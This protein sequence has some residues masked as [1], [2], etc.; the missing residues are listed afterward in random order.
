M[1]QD[2]DSFEARLAAVN[3]QFSAKLPERLQRI[4]THWRNWLLHP[5][6]CEH[7]DQLLFEIHTLKGTAG[8][9]NRAD[10]S[11]ICVELETLLHKEPL[12]PETC[13]KEINQLVSQLQS[14]IQSPK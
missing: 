10:I 9:F 6:Q 4:T 5:S 1:S 2:N 13:Q 11:A 14:E 7:F 3:T 8:T 12:A